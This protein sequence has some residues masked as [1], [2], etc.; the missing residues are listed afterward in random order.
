MLSCRAVNLNSCMQKSAMLGAPF[1]CSFNYLQV[2]GFF[3]PSPTP[4]GKKRKGG[5]IHEQIV[6]VPH[7]IMSKKGLK[8]KENL[9]T[10]S[11]LLRQSLLKPNCAAF[12]HFVSGLIYCYA[13]KRF[14]ITSVIFEI[15]GRV[16]L[17][18]IQMH[19][20]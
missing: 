19:N 4:A 10:F 8:K 7:L 14:L 2:W 16:G 13:V 9:H 5:G 17:K 11:N 3:F 12:L 1:L 6:I 15:L 20:L 18:C